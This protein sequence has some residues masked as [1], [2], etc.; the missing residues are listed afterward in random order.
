MQVSSGRE[1]KVGVER[2]DAKKENAILDSISRAEGRIGRKHPAN[3]RFCRLIEDG[4]Y[5]L[6]CFQ[7]D[8]IGRS[9]CPVSDVMKGKVR[10]EV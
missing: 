2:A 5:E 9:H 3:P 10:Y 6:G 7:R 8:I 4:V 1:L